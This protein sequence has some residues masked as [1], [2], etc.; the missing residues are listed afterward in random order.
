MYHAGRILG[1]FSLAFVFV[2]AAAEADVQCGDV[3][4]EDTT[5]TNDVIC[6]GGQVISFGSDNVTLDLGGYSIIGDAAA[7][8]PIG[9]EFRK[10]VTLKN[11]TISGFPHHLSVRVCRDITLSN[12]MFE[13]SGV[14]VEASTGVKI[15]NS[16]FM[17]ASSG[18]GVFAGALLGPGGP[19]DSYDVQ[20]RNVDIHSYNVGL[21]IDRV[22]RATVTDS[23][24]SD[25]G[26]GLRIHGSRRV[27]VT[28]S[29]FSNNGT[30]ADIQ[31]SKLTKLTN[32]NFLDSR[33]GV[34]VE[35][36]TEVQ[37]E[38]NH[39][40]GQHS[41][42]EDFCVLGTCCAGIQTDDGTIYERQIQ[43]NVVHDT[44]NGIEMSNS[45]YTLIAHNR[46]FDNK[47]GIV[48]QESSFYNQI[49]SNIAFGN[50]ELDLYHWPEATANVWKNNRCD[51][52]K[53]EGADISDCKFQVIVG[54]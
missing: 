16:S 14:Q 31:D 2:S 1:V 37:I 7:F 4:T 42:C 48:L 9:L 11:G 10:K 29:N 52:N 49:T 32:S 20:I 19:G 47:V 45:Y 43:H 39:I 24:F 54:E 21:Y 30:G 46:V 12:L 15:E 34:H 5:L 50:E 28:N 3:I 6:T 44:D 33:I 8:G 36:H 25:N 23:N 26:S 27:T 17:G 51:N 13:G 53:I 40:S 41:S 22:L 18:I 38:K 35:G